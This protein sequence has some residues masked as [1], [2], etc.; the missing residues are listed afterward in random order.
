M[1]GDWYQRWREL[2]DDR[3]IP[4]R[5][6]TVRSIDAAAQRL[7][8]DF[9]DH[10]DSDPALDGPGAAW[11]HN[12]KVGDEV[13]VVGPDAR[14]AQSHIGMDWKPGCATDVLLVGD[15]TAA[16]AVAGILAQLP[17]DHQAL[18]ASRGIHGLLATRP[19]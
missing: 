14:S 17:A 4:F 6:Y 5:T 8:V 2:P 13:I 9:V 12:A 19:S 18:T 1:R 3:R 7:Q 15:E 11:L 10:V 16:P